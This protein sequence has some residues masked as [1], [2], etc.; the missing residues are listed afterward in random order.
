MAAIEAKKFRWPW[1][2]INLS[3][4]VECAAHG[5]HSSPE[6]SRTT[7]HR[8]KSAEDSAP[9]ETGAAAASASLKDSFDPE[10]AERLR[11][12]RGATKKSAK[13][14]R[15]SSQK[16][17]YN[18]AHGYI[19]C[20][21]HPSLVLGVL[22]GDNGLNEVFLQKK[23]EDNINQRWLLKPNGVFL[24]KGR[25]NMALT[26]KLPPIESAK[27]DLLAHDEE[28]EQ[29]QEQAEKRRLQSI[30]ANA[31]IVLQPLVDFEN[32]NAHQKFYVD[33]KIG[34]IYAFATSDIYNIEIM[35]A[36]KAN[37]CSH[38][39]TYD[40]ELSQPVSYFDSDDH[41]EKF[42][43]F[44]FYFYL[45]LMLLRVIYASLNKL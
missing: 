8:H 18:R 25:A 40:K 33:E 13:N 10:L 34:F 31:A 7:L 30:Y 21:E 32:G 1:E 23:S 16:F 14:A 28:E 27:I 37:I 12:L 45:I 3:K 9:V 24:L 39:V 43:F 36:N 2:Q 44:C 26:V 5:N 19:Y 22:E 29:E 4:S 6:R 15:L 17:A 11:P 38:Y 20:A 35:A 41:R 42:V